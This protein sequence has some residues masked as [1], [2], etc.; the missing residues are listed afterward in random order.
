MSIDNVT[1]VTE[2]RINLNKIDQQYKIFKLK[3]LEQHK[4]KQ[5]EQK[6]LFVLKNRY[7]VIKNEVSIFENKMTSIKNLLVDKILE[8][9]QKEKFLKDLQNKVF[10][11]RETYVNKINEF[12]E[13]NQK[14]NDSFEK[15]V[16]DSEQIANL[17]IKQEMLSRL[18]GQMKALA[19]FVT[20]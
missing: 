18:E 2:Y 16:N 13:H 19:Y 8:K 11:N 17:K 6:E 10:E 9:K 20:K 1:N 4:I 15:R 12:I 5:N 14:L 7:F 3:L